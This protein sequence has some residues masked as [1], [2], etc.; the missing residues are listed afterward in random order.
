ML[1]I[2]EEIRE[3]G[4]QDER[5]VDRTLKKLI[6]AAVLQNKAN[7]NA[8]RAERDRA[9]RR[10]VAARSARATALRAGAGTAAVKRLLSGL[11]KQAEA[12]GRDDAGC[13]PDC[14]D[15]HHSHRGPPH[16]REIAA[17][18]HIGMPGIRGS[19]PRLAIEP[20]CFIRVCI[21]LNCLRRAL[22]SE[23]VTPE[24]LAIRLRREPFRIVGS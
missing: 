18:G 5:L 22:T 7:A 8:L 19:F 12:I 13:G 2:A 6:T 20:N 1:A 3:L 11:R 15:G 24:P 17:R 10:L 4:A 14:Q 23:T 9:E 21:S 16:S